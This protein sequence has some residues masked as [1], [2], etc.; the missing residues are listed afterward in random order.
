[1]SY[2]QPAYNQPAALSQDS[3]D[4]DE[5]QSIL[6]AEIIEEIKEDIP[7]FL[8]GPMFTPNEI[9]F[10]YAM[11]DV[12]HNHEKIWVAHREAWGNKS[13]RMVVTWLILLTA[14]LA[15]I[16]LLVMGWVESQDIGIKPQPSANIFKHYSKDGVKPWWQNIQNWRPGDWVNT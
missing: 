7:G 15:V 11:H 9:D 12:I 13:I 16:T 6:L 4:R 5:S 2:N 3:R 10:I 14:W 1:M 8:R